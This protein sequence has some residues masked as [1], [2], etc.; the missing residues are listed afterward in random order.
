MSRILL[1]ILIAG[2]VFLIILFVS[3][4]DLWQDF[5]LWIVGLAGP[6]VKIADL[7]FTKVKHWVTGTS[8]NEDAD[9]IAKR[10]SQA[11]QNEQ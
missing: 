7:M 3:R 5:W 2:G 6:I 1:L 11:S 9:F 10:T 4:P 8:N